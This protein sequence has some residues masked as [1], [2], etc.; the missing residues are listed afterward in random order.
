[1]AGSLYGPLVKLRRAREHYEALT[2][3][4]PR[5]PKSQMYRLVAEFDADALEYRFYVPRLQSVSPDALALLIGDT[6]FNLRSALDQLVYELH[7]RRF[8][9]KVPLD[10]E[11]QSEFPI[12]LKARSE[13]TSKWREIKRLAQKERARIEWLQPYHARNDQMRWVR[14]GLHQLAVLHNID[15]HRRFH[16]V[17]RAVNLAAVPNFPPGY[18]FT[19]TATFGPVEEGAQIDCWAFTALP[20]NVAREVQMHIAFI[21]EAFDEPGEFPG[22]LPVMVVLQ[23]I[24]NR[25]LE[26][27]KMFGPLFP[28][29]VFPD[30]L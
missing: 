13:P 29:T 5:D 23:A 24:H 6:L 4:C 26:I 21:D 18:G 15:K 22:W 30:P 1:M 9:G 12:L 16:V 17:R 27:I 10:A 11:R 8:R 20:P 25:V 3:I 19:S 7:V 28:V 2:A 14:L